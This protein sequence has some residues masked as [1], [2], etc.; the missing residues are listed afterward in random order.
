MLIIAAILF[1][2]FG[3]SLRLG[4]YADTFKRQA[5]MAHEDASKALRKHKTESSNLG[6]QDQRL[7][8][9][10]MAR[11]PHGYGITD[12]KEQSYRK[13]LPEPEVC[14]SE[15]IQQQGHEHDQGPA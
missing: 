10:L 9:F 2:G 5:E 1:G 3:Q 6:N 14:M 4:N 8:N 11:D 7:Q 13:L 12:F 15:G